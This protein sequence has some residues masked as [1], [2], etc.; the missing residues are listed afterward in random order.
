MDQEQ[1]RVYRELQAHCNEQADRLFA[2][3]YVSP[4]G[5]V[6]AKVTPEEKLL[7]RKAA[8]YARA[9]QRCEEMA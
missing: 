8:G 6:T 1:A 5:K 3:L 4:T 2:T 9:A 7:R